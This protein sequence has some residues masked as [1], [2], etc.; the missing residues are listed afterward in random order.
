MKIRTISGA[1]FTVIVAAFF[2]LREYVDTRLF[3]IFI[4]FI[5]TVGTFEVA[6]ALKQHLY[7]GFYVTSIIYGACFVPIYCIAEYLLFDG[8]GFLFAIGFA[9]LF[10][11][12]V[13][14][15]AA[16]NG[17]GLKKFAVNS[18]VVAY[19]SLLFLCA[20][21]TNDLSGDV[22]FIGMLLIF[23]VAACADTMAYLVGM[24]YN[25][26][27]KG[28]AKKLC[29]KLSPKK[30]VAGAV[31]G[32]IGGSLGALLCY[33]VCKPDLGISFPIPFFIAFGIVGSIFTEVG[34]LFESG[35]KRA[36]GIKDMGRIMPGHGGVM[37]RFDGMSF[38]AV[39]T[40]FTLLA[41]TAL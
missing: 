36:V 35:I 31:G 34:D 14:A 4:W 20:A 3:Q 13:L 17:G 41:V 9:L 10:E 39:L 38:L 37:D 15:A 12:C 8:Y 2:L 5:C 40:Y 30:T 22:G 18:L 26:I 1:C 28:Q 7:K 19:P 32:L 29:P 27:R 25:K 23:V 21:L 24:V 11:L 6:R 16:I 33:V